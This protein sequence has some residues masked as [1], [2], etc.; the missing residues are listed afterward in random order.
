M[1]KNLK[2]RARISASG[3]YKQNPANKKLEK[4]RNLRAVGL[5]CQRY[6]ANV[7]F[8]FC[9]PHSIILGITKKLCFFFS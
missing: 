5:A 9:I 2:C 6:D 8:S 7:A 3:E 1:E 4:K